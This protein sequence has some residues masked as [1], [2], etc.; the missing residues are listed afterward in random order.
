M[1]GVKKTSGASAARGVGYA[2]AKPH[3]NAAT[4]E[5]AERTDS[6]GLSDTARELSSALCMV[7]ESPEVRAEKIAALKAQIAAGTY[8]P[9]PREVARKLIERGF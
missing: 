9:D 8:N 3:A 1:A 7:E 2:F 5:R 4:V 6:A